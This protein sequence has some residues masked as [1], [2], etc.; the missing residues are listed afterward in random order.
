MSAAVSLLLS[1][2]CIYLIVRSTPS[3]IVSRLKTVEELA[4]SATALCEKFSR[5][6]LDRQAEFDTFVDRCEE[7]L[8][9]AANKQRRAAASASR[10]ARTEAESAPATEEEQ[11][12]ALRKVAGLV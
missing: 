10:A 11:L 8:Q 5:E 12:L 6:R 1:G 2:V 7:L 4:T 3:R 9:A